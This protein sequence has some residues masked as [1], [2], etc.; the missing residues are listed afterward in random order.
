MESIRFYRTNEPFGFLSG[1]YRAPFELDGAVWPTIEH[2]YQA[3]KFPDKTRQEAIRM[4][5]TPSEAK[6]LGRQSDAGMRPDWDTVRD[7]VM[8]RALRA[9]F[10]QH[11]GLRAQLLATGDAQLIEN[12]Y[13]DLY[14]GD[15][16]NG[17]GQ[18]RLGHLLMQVRDEL[19]A[20]EQR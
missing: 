2:Y 9:K 1:H 4:A 15:G 19:R 16:G 13:S 14:W 11:A 17:S 3:Q 12:S 6:R 7:E 10:D 18:N 5:A 8:L 20:E